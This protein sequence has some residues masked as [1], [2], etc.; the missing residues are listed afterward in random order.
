MSAVDHVRPPNLDSN[1]PFLD[2]TAEECID[3]LASWPTPSFI[4]CGVIER[5]G[6]T[7]PRVMLFGLLP[8]TQNDGR[9]F[10]HALVWPEGIVGASPD[11]YRV[12]LAGYA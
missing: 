5:G 6:P 4:N 11:L 7:L 10:I 9:R 2:L 3:L 8:Y 12:L 1:P